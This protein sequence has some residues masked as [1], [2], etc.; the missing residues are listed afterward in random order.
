MYRQPYYRN[1]PPNVTYNPYLQSSYQS[2]NPFQR[3]PVYDS[4]IPRSPYYQRQPHPE[5]QYYGGL[6]PQEALLQQERARALA[7]RQARRAQYLP[8]EED[9]VGSDEEW[10][11]SQLGPRE[12]AYVDARR[13]A[14]ALEHQRIE[15]E[16]ARA[17][18][19]E[20]AKERKEEE[21]KMRRFRQAELK[22][23]QEEKRRQFQQRQKEQHELQERVTQESPR[24]P[25]PKKFEPVVVYGAD[26]QEAA[27]IQRQYR[28]HQS[29]KA[30]SQYAK[31]FEELKK[32]F[33]Y[34]CNIDFQQAGQDEGI[35][36]VRATHPPSDYNR[37]LPMEDEETSPVSEGKLAYTSTNY[38]LHQYSDSIDKLLIKLDGVESWGCKGV[39][40]RR[41][42]IVK[43]IGREAARLDW[44]WREAWQD[45]VRQQAAVTQ[46]EEVK[47]EPVQEEQQQEESTAVEVESPV[48]SQQ[49]TTTPQP[50][51]EDQPMPD[52]EQVPKPAE[53]EPMQED[54]PQ[55]QSE[56]EPAPS[57]LPVVEDSKP[58]PQLDGPRK[59]PITVVN[60]RMEN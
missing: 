46:K 60:S 30:L 21:A 54:E 51:V 32:N 39:R 19:A 43:S 6:S 48:Q 40:D 26:H 47:E 25:T 11:Y 34:P 59:I 45:Y 57:R 15:Q 20:L 14:E 27:K 9:S 50:P 55:S 23:I 44:Y 28:I 35:I 18:E 56:P 8:D 53:P 29:F 17:R 13:R 24:P 33:V 2:N 7:E 16:K 31:Q 22:K 36:T 42:S 4:A 3:V 49:E 5:S 1:H 58:E 12:R 41:R 37:D 10:E 52:E 38:N